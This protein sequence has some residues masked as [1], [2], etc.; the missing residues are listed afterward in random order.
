[1]LDEA[2]EWDCTLMDVLEDEPEYP[3]TESSL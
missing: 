2:K 1:M 3:D